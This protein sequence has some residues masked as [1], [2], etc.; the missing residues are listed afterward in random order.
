[1]NIKNI[2]YVIEE[3]LKKE[4]QNVVVLSGGLE[5]HNITIEKLIKQKVWEM[6]TLQKM[7]IK[8]KKELVQNHMAIQTKMKFYINARKKL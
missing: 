7:L 6:E 1:M 3:H 8:L 2:Q 4:R 5:Y